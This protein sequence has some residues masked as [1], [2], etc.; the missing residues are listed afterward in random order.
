[1]VEPSTPIMPC[2]NCDG[3]IPWSRKKKIY[4]T[5]FCKEEA[6]HIRWI[7]STIIR[8]VYSNPDVALARETRIHQLNRGGYIALGRRIPA[9]TRL[10]VKS[11]Y[12]E[13][14]A[15]CSDSN[16]GSHQI[17]HILGSSNS[18]ENL[19]L[20]CTPCHSLKTRKSVSRSDAHFDRIDDYREIKK[21]FEK[22]LIDNY[23]VHFEDIES[24]VFYL[25][26]KAKDATPEDFVQENMDNITSDDPRKEGKVI[27]IQEIR[28]RVFAPK[29]MKECDNSKNWTKIEPIIQT[30][31][32]MEYFHHILPLVQPLL[33]DKLNMEKIGQRMNELTIPTYSGGAT[34]ARKNV[35][36]MLDA[37][38]IK[39][40]HNRETGEFEYSNK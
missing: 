20:L 12:D 27:Q 5:D 15:I 32:K 13:K 17:D 26:K 24:D 3:Q 35:K 10:L 31:R 34:W 25:T 40:N 18:I 4:C 37:L 21:I 11:K 33:D 9:E 30:K 14:C 38:G 2:V 22:G 1:M 19:Q 29:P 16:I 28:K 23:D 8:G 36:A 7:R 39:A 6:K